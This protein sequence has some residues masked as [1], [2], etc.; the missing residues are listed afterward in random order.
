MEAMIYEEAFSIEQVYFTKTDKKVNP[1]KQ[2]PFKYWPGSIPVLIS[3]PHSVRHERRK[4]IKVSDQ[5]T[6]SLAY[7]IHK[8]T[9]AHALAVTKLY[10][11]DPN[12]DDS[13]SYK[14]YLAKISSENKISLIVDLHGA[15]KERDFDIDL[16]TMNGASL[17]KKEI[18]LEDFIHSFEN[19]NFKKISHNYF[20]GS[21]QNTV[22]KFSALQL[23]IPAIQLEI[24]RKYRAPNQ[25]PEAY[26]N[27]VA[28]IV[29]SIDS[30]LTINKN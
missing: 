20:S 30:F 18:I 15:S 19:N 26:C 11:G 17:L 8:I 29:D 7:L 10:G 24:N 27:L 9:G 4:K 14:N 25:N 21:V 2:I 16:G 5:F 22:I 23:M 28:A 6:G 13:C 3:A 12:F 1:K